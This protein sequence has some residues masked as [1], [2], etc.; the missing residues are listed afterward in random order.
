MLPSAAHEDRQQNTV[1]L[2]PCKKVPLSLI[3]GTLTWFCAIA[4]SAWTRP[5]A[6]SD[7][8]CCAPRF[9][10]VA[11][12][13]ITWAA[14]RWAKGAVG[15][16]SSPLHISHFQVHLPR[17]PATGQQAVLLQPDN[18]VLCPPILYSTPTANMAND[19]YDVRPISS[20]FPH[21]RTIIADLMPSSSFSS[22]VRYSPPTPLTRPPSTSLDQHRN[23]TMLTF[24]AR[25]R[26]YRRLRCRK[27]Q[28]A[29]SIHP[30]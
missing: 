3:P 16:A 25:S 23:P 5:G 10:R 22:R 27:V 9:L 29:E 13:R 30:Q 7:G 17:Y 24:V 1:V 2:L 28:S 14:L 19:E 8:G 6:G 12:L 4:P 20:L 11:Y 18:D 26:P 15:A 21:V